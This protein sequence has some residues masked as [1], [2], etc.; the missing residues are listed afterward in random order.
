MPA[1]VLAKVNGFLQPS[2]V[3]TKRVRM[4]LLRKIET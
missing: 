2:E 1:M 3:D 4:L